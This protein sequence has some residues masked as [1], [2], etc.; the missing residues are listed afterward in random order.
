MGDG[1][2]ALEPGL[3]GAKRARRVALNDEQGGRGR[4]ALA[5]RPPDACDMG[6]GLRE[7]GTIKLN[8]RHMAEVVIGKIEAG[9]LTCGDDQAAKTAR[10][11]RG[12][13][14]RQLYG[15]GTSADDQPDFSSTQPSP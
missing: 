2:A 12:G 6:V 11:E 5:K 1:N 4:E 10:R 3:G 9:M 14:R 15:F 13:D 8:A 7:A